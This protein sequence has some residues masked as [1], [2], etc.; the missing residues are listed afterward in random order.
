MRRRRGLLSRRCWIA[1]ACRFRMPRDT[2]GRPGFTAITWAVSSM[3]IAPRPASLWSACGLAAGFPPTFRKCL[4]PRIYERRLSLRWGV[5]WRQH[6]GCGGRRPNW[7]GPGGR[8]GVA[9]VRSP[10]SPEAGCVRHQDQQRDYR[11]QVYHER[12]AQAVC[13]RCGAEEPVA[14]GLCAPCHQAYQ[15]HRRRQARRGYAR[16]KATG[17]CAKS[18]CPDLTEPGHVYCASHLEAIRLRSRRWYVTHGRLR[19]HSHG[20]APGTKKTTP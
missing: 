20:R 19:R 5:R 7:P 9:C 17:Q 2:A 1:K 8:A 15:I 3:S 14:G 16:R 6:A 11:R 4:K 13:Y 18:R 12:R 10:L